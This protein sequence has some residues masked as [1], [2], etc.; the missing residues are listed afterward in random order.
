LGT[1]VVGP[2][3]IHDAGVLGLPLPHNAKFVAIRI[4]SWPPEEGKFLLRWSAPQLQ[5]TLS[6]A[7]VVLLKTAPRHVGSTH[8]PPQSTMGESHGTLTVPPVPEL[9]PLLGPAPLEVADPPEAF[10]PP[11]A[12][13]AEEPP[14]AREPPDPLA[15]PVPP[16]PPALLSHRP[17]THVP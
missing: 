5:V 2:R 7:Q 6:H 16:E 1:R 8:P 9:D 10:D 11:D 4:T 3:W 15:P 12:L 13:A 14:D 17:P